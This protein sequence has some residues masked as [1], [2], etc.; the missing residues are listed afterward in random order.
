MVLRVSKA[1]FFHFKI[2]KLPE[3]DFFEAVAGCM[4]LVLLGGISIFFF[5]ESKYG[6]KNVKFLFRKIQ[7]GEEKMQ[8]TEKKRFFSVFPIL[9]V[10]IPI[11]LWLPQ[12]ARASEAQELVP[13]G[14]TVGVTM[15]TKGLLVLGTGF[16]SGEDNET[17]EPSKGVLKIGDLILQAD[18]KELEN[19]EAFLTAVENSGGEPM[20][21][22]LERDGRKKEVKITP[23]FSM[24]DQTYKIG[25]WI[26]DSIQGIGTVTY[27][28]PNNGN[29]G[30][31]GHG[32]Y[33][34]DTGEL[35]SIREGS[36]LEADLT[37]IIK[38]EKGKAGELT[39]KVDTEGKLACIEKNTEAG[40]YGTAEK[41][42]FSGAAFSIA[43]A[44][45]IRK[46]EAVLLSNLEGGAV[47]EYSLKI[48]SINRN[49]GKNN[50][51]MTI[52]I[53]DEELLALTGGIVQGMSGSPIL[54]DGKLIGAVT[55]VMVNDPTRGY[56]I[57]I[58]NMLEAAE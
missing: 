4:I 15:D 48:E 9:A 39:G 22:L 13:V 29:F 25:V 5:G 17:Y 43:A 16:V 38:G 42:A 2:K 1:P 40:I 10:L 50:K 26:R 6:A 7:L 56:G 23:V 3:D 47:K 36:L 51:D 45:E 32:V 53:T 55:H 14:Q 31:L 12:T 37:E 8:Q 33:D 28:D 49:G 58:E 34:V 46:G 19:K 52:R 21:L 54:Q 35:M 57:F 30:A 24:A 20:K 11:L 27:Y 41:A 44:E 18:G